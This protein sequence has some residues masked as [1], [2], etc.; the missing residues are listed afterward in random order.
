ME[1][2]EDLPN[3]RR[4][5]TLARLASVVGLL[6]SLT[7]LISTGV[8][9]PLGRALPVEVAGPLT[10]GCLALAAIGALLLPR[11]GTAWRRRVVVLLGAAVE[12]VAIANLMPT[13]HPA[14]MSAYA[15]AALLLLGLALL[16]AVRDGRSEGP[17]QVLAVGSMAIA[18]FVLIGYAYDVR[19]I[20]RGTATIPMSLDVAVAVSLIGAGVA[21]ARPD[22]GPM[23]LLAEDSPG[24]TL[25]R[26]TLPAFLVAPF[27]LG[28]LRLQGE[29]AG[30]YE[31]WFGVA[32]MTA[33]MAASFI[34]LTWWNAHALDRRERERL[35]AREALGRAYEALAEADRHKDEFLAVASHEL[36]TPLNVVL[37]YLS[38]LQEGAGGALNPEQ[39]A[40]ADKGMAG[41]ERLRLL[42]DDIVDYARIVS[43]RLPLDPVPTPYE[44]LVEDVVAHLRPVAAARRIAIEVDAADVG[45]PCL[46]GHRIGQVLAK[47]LDNGI[48]F[49]PDG[50]RIVVRV[51]RTGVRLQT[52]IA[53][54][55]PGVGEDARAR[56]F[57]PFHQADMSTTRAFGGLGL[58][59]PISK[60]IVEAH[61]GTI[62]FE[63]GPGSGATFWFTLPAFGDDEDRADAEAWTARPLREALSKRPD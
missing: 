7:S 3:A 16:L 25:L 33:L 40:F 54:T 1:I 62:G 14:A 5:A 39:Q 35:R 48:K 37:G 61:G 27:V 41:V 57:H 38:F 12:L 9:L 42:I 56:I 29:R 51:W 22:R 23:R 46:D 43:G 28:W 11:A 44:A 19:S 4:L 47:L 18:L 53:D 17:A 31:T 30:L 45:L 2:G 55:G 15:A 21:F 20:I 6:I 63:S 59:L 32:L 24:G 34:G 13:L 36:R 8:A 49:T 58:G 10:G 60:G 50:G 52:A 26:R